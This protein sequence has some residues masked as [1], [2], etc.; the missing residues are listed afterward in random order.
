MIPIRLP[1]K[2]AVSVIDCL[3]KAI[4][5]ANH[6][7]FGEK[8]HAKCIGRLYSILGEPSV[9]QVGKDTLIDP[10][11]V[12]LLSPSCFRAPALS[13]HWVLG[14]ESARSDG[15]TTTQCEASGRGNQPF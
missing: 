15:I 1:S 10:Q 7:V 14:H 12:M 4:Y 5:T 2:I 3:F 8:R 6:T 13:M 11:T 9:S